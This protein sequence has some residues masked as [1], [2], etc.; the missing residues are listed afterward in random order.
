MRTALDDPPALEHVDAVGGDDICKSVGDQNNGPCLRELMD[1][2]PDQL[3]ALHIYVGGGF[4][5]YIHRRIMQQSPCEREPLA[6]TAGQVAS[7]LGDI[8]VKILLFIKIDQLQNLR[9]LLIRRLGI[10]E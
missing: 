3:L 5:K 4:V 8:G 1:N 10:P 7:V 6:L 2:P 9:H